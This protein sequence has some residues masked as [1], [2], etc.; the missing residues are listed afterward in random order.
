MRSARFVNVI[1]LFRNT[2]KYHLKV[3]K[4]QGDNRVAATC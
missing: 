2:V 1:A 3:I 4:Q